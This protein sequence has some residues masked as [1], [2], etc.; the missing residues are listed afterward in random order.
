MLETKY[1]HKLV[2]E[3]KYEITK[4]ILIYFHKSGFLTQISKGWIP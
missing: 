4:A 1:N 3:N 2:E